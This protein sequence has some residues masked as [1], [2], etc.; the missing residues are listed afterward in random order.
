[1]SNNS[2][3]TL[4]EST[5]LEQ[6][7]QEPDSPFYG[8][9]AG[10]S[11]T[12]F[13]LG[14]PL[15]LLCLFYFVKKKRSNSRFLYL[16]INAV[17]ATICSL[18]IFAALSSFY[19]GDEML[20]GPKILCAL[21][22]MVWNITQGLSVFLIAVLSISRTISLV[23]PL[24]HISRHQVT[25]PVLVYTVLLVLQATI[26]YWFGASY[27][28]DSKYVICGWYFPDLKISLT[29][30]NILFTLL[31]PCQLLPPLIAVL[32]SCGI[33][34]VKMWG[35][36]QVL[37]RADDANKRKRQGTITVVILTAAYAFFNVPCCATMMIYA[38]EF[39]SDWKINVMESVPGEIIALIYALA[40]NYTVV[41]NSIVNALIY[42]CRI[43]DLR[44]FSG[45]NVLLGYCSRRNRPDRS[46]AGGGRS[47]IEDIQ[48]QPRN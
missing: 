40:Y 26:P 2:I 21:Q 37:T 32:V 19:S 23:F 17:D 9:Y 43:K 5:N 1:M 12:Q 6:G 41:G 24:K 18:G 30:Q 29:S 8:L 10:L 38:I 48:L 46:G 35:S 34:C 15:N 47:T 11:T 20:H 45:L 25:L 7:L 14:T 42:I 3:T 22:G 39:V 16:C 31:F 27:H 36:S 44:D 28:Y 13:L 33:T 4:P